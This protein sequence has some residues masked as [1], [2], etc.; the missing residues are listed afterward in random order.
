MEP[1]KTRR[2]TDPESPG[3]PVPWER[4]V[5]EKLLVSTVSEARRARR[6]NIFFKFLLFGYLALLV[7][8]AYWDTWT[9]D[10]IKRKDHTAL[11]E[12]EG[13][14]ASAD[15]GVDADQVVESLEKAFK[16]K[17]TKAVMLRINSP[18]GSP[19]Q[20]ADIYG[21]I[22]RLRDKHPDIPVY[23]VVSDVAAS[24]GYYIAA[25]AD[26]IY[27]NRSSIVGSIGVRMDQFGFVGAME[28]LGV[29]RRLLT[30]GEHKGILDPFLPLADTERA[31][32]QGL[33][34]GIHEQFIQ[35]VREGRGDRLADDPDIFSG[36]YWTGEEGL[37]LGLVDGFGD[38]RH[39]AR[40]VVG[41]EEI[42]DFTV[43]EDVW[44]RLARRVGT[45][46]GMALGSA[47]GLEGRPGVR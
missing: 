3:T 39:V 11:V 36:L 16:D 35:A 47:F 34:D 23:A 28:K 8:L 19:V 40:E 21:E 44:T 41:E 14:I 46:I 5:V 37:E 1:G 30:A 4:E 42:V 26:R 6:W 31:H 22:R 7:V 29:E 33:L 13:I 15:L 25:A 43:E 17:H 12:I 2:G 24:G 27:A 45:G 10:G 20:S 18:G 32:A 9:G 38:T